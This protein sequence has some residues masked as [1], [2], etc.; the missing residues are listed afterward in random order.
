METRVSLSIIFRKCASRGRSGIP[1]HVY[2]E[3]EIIVVCGV[4]N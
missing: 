3:E 1:W 4:D 2:D